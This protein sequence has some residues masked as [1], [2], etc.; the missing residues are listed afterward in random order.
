MTEAYR[1]GHVEWQKTEECFRL[2]V[3]S[4]KDYGIFTLD[5]KGYIMTWNEGA[6]RIKGYEEHEIVGSHFSR[7]YSP[8]DLAAQKPQWELQRAIADGRVEDE[9]WRM[10]KDG[11]YFWANVIITPLFDRQTGELRGFGKVTRDLTEWKQTGERLRES[12]EQF[13]LLVERVEEYAIFMIDPTGHIATWN[14]GAEK[15]KGYK[16]EEIVGEHIE[17][18]YTAE[19]RAAGRPAQLLERAKKE[20]HVRDQ[21]VRVRKGG[22]LFQ[23]DVLITA[24]HDFT[25]NLRGFSKVTRDV[26]DQARNREVEAAKLLA[27]QANQAKDD[28]LAVL[29]HE[30]RTP[31]TPVVAGVTYICENAASLSREELLEELNA[32]RRNVLLETQLID[33]L[34]DLTRI[35]RGKIELRSEVVDLH[36]ALEDVLGILR[37]EIA[38]KELTLAR[39]LS[40]EERWIWG[41]PTRLRQIFWNLI[42]NAVKFTP[43]GGRIVVHSFGDSEGQL[44][45]EITDS[46][47]GIEPEQAAR[48][49]EAF[50]Q[51]ERTVTRKFGGLGLG[52]AITRS[53]V[54]M[55]KGSVKVQSAGK[56]QGATFTVTLPVVPNQIVEPATSGGESPGQ[57]TLRILFVD[58]HEDTRRILARLLSTRGHHVEI[59]N[60]VASA[61]ACLEKE[62]FDVLL[63]DIGLPDGSGHELMREAKRRQAQIKGIAVSGFGMDEDIRRSA[64]AGFGTHLAKPL[65]VGLLENVLRRL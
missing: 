4:V 5:P 12:E 54:E 46:G 10:R 52:L 55:H 1:P 63:S 35:S 30:L 16:V 20:G 3:E 40:A 48:I 41:D 50:E 43:R 34:L 57:R 38:A 25:G 60:G 23:A 64:E 59:A 7:F 2:L 14:S 62:K 13:R 37:D 11:S 61:L 31:L 45:V 22:S 49:F 36:A 53:L 26:T 27:E 15:I 39:D 28:F 18:F 56:D 33:D 58:D 51:G 8:E 44:A 32:I 6:K 47:V 9:G 24:V 17:R 65:D 29:S 21:G 19:D 42:N